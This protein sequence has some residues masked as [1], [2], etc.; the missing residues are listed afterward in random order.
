[1]TRASSATR[2]FATRLI[3]HDTKA[4]RPSE[5]EGPGVQHIC[6]KLRPHL[7]TL[8][9][10]TG[11]RALL[12]RALALANK[13]VPWLRD[14]HVKSDGSLEGL[15]ELPAQ[16]LPDK[17]VEGNVVLLARVLGLLMAFIGK[18]LTIRLVRDVWPEAPLDG[19]SLGDEGNHDETE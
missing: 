14:V 11:F 6:E 8:M 19:V 7:A 1:M 13:E 12:S 16:L 2:D 5:T 15:E 17:I 3:A 10:N 4:N 18:N 9:G